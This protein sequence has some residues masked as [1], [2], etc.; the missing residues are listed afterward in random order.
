MIFDTRCAVAYF[1]CSVCSSYL[2]T[3][4]SVTCVT[5]RGW[6]RMAL[7]VE[8]ERAKWAEEPIIH[9][10]STVDVCSTVLCLGFRLTQKK[11]TLV[12]AIQAS[13]A[14]GVVS[15]CVA[16]TAGFRSSLRRSLANLCVD[17]FQPISIRAT[18]YTSHLVTNQHMTE[19]ATPVLLLQHDTV[20]F[21]TMDNICMHG[22]R[23][24]LA[25]SVVPCITLVYACLWAVLTH[26]PSSCAHGAKIMHTWTKGCQMHCIGRTCRRPQLPMLC[27]ACT[28][29]LA[30]RLRT[31]AASGA[32]I[33]PAISAGL[34]VGA[35]LCIVLP[36]GFVT[37]LGSKVSK[38]IHISR[39]SALCCR[40][41]TGD[42]STPPHHGATP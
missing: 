35:A 23:G 14:H 25:R 28:G 30:L 1:G 16:A 6:A 33:A 19:Q 18:L 5:S 37:F 21:S 32:S 31:P 27:T 2:Y 11:A 34:L 38:G 39:D 12:T 15:H 8:Q 24:I 4:T 9:E 29:L 10:H 17:L 22:R 26:T 13:G 40:C 20:S 41:K 3:R 7:I 42:Q 36:E